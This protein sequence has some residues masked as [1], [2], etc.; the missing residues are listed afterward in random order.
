MRLFL[1]AALFVG[2]LNTLAEITSDHGMITLSQAQ[3]ESYGITTMLL[4]PATEVL[5]ARYPAEVAVPNSQLQVISVLQGGLVEALMVAE[6]D[7]VS[8]DQKIGRASCRER[9]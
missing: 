8:K 7:H 9:V 4:Q 3:K 6:G 5:G 2:S 1:F